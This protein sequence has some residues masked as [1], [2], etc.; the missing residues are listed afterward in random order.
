M[1][2]LRLRKRHGPV[3]SFSPPRRSQG[4]CTKVTRFLPVMFSRSRQHLLLQVPY[5][6]VLQAVGNDQDC[7]STSSEGGSETPTPKKVC[8]RDPYFVEFQAAR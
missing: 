6:F 3:D 2:I 4:S 8:G 1:L 7:S 5:R